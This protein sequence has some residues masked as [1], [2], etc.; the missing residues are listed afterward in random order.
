MNITKVESNRD[1]KTFIEV[2]LKIYK[3]DKNWIRQLDK[4]INSVLR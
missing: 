2:P 4:V 1:K 3:N